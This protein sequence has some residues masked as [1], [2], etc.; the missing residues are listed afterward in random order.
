MLAIRCV[1]FEY[2]WGIQLEQLGMQVHT[3]V[4]R[5]AETEDRDSGVFAFE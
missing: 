2:L 1:E 3:E 5:K 4:Q